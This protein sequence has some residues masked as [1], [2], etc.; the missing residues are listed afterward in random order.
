MSDDTYV[1]VFPSLFAENKIRLLMANIKK[2]LKSQNQN[3]TRIVR[4]GNIIL[5][6]AN[7]PVFASSSINLLFG[8]KQVII[9]KQIKNDFKTVVSEIS[10]VGSN[11][12]LK[13]EKFYVSIEGIPKGYVVKDAE[14]AAT[15]SLIEQNKK[16]GAMPGT[17]EKHD[18]L[19]FTYITKSSAYV[20]IFTD[21]GL[22]GTVNNSQ[23]QRILC[24]IFD[25]FSAISCL[26]T[27]KQGFEVKI[28]VFY[29]KHSELVNLVKILQKIIPRTLETTSNIEFYKMQISGSKLITKNYLVTE[30]LSK[31]ASKEKISH[32][33]LSLS[34]LVFPS[35]FMKKLQT[36]VFELGLIPVIPLSGID[37]GIFDNAREID[38]EKYI[39]KIEKLL[40]TKVLEKPQS[41]ISSSTI[42]HILKSRKAVSIKS[43]PNMIH[44]V[45]DSL[46]VKH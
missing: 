3:F 30:I 15:S 28:V 11:L 31:I 43:G 14:L 12:L 22:G 34:P 35:S 24:G 6:E 19:L 18:K 33:S 41:K 17:K 20:S 29:Q 7:D 23:N 45:L 36:R 46:E 44:E 26:E 27:I 9:A 25:E 1:I 32:I 38:L 13:G 5:V 2:I 21:K 39:V 10:K 4:D 16:N 42:N 40:R 37:S 8:I